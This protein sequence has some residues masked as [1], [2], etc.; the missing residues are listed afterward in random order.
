MSLF[1]DL[2]NRFSKTTD[3]DNATPLKDI[4]QVADQSPDELKLVANI[5]EKINLVR[6][7]NSR[8]ALE[9]IY[10]TNLAY[11]MGFDG[12]YYD[13]TYRMFKNIDP[14]RKVTRSRYK[15][16]KILASIQ[17]RLARLVQNPPRYDVMPESPS[18]K[19]K[20]SA[21]LGIKL[22]GD[23][24]EKNRFDE[25]RQDLLMSCMQGGVA[26]VKVKWDPT[27]G[28]PM[29]DPETDE[30]VGYEGD[31]RLEVLN[32]LEVYPDPLAKKLEDCQYVIE[33]KVRKL[34]Y[35]K[36]QYP[37]RGHAVKEE[38]VW[39]L[40][41][42][43]DL[44]ANALTAVGITGAQTKD[45]TRDSAI[46]IT[47]YE[48]R[49]KNYPNGRQVVQASGVLL[50][51]KELPAGIFDIVKFD[52]ILI[53]GRYNSEAVITHLRPIQDQF[54]ITR[55]RM[56]DWIRKNLAG[57]YI[58]PKGSELMEESINNADSEV[59]EYTTVPG[60]PPPT[61]MNIPAIPAYAYNDIKEQGL[62]FDYVSGINEVSR[63]VLPS[64]SIPAQ[65]MALLQ[66]QDQTRI[67]VQATRNEVG[68]S[69]VGELILRYAGKYYIL[70]RMYKEAGDGLEYTV[71]EF[72]GSDLNDN[73]DVRVVPGSTIP[74]SKV[75][76]RQDVM[77]VYNS[78][79]MG[80]PMDDKVKMKA[81]NE[82]EFGDTA[83]IWKSQAL[84]SNQ[85]KKSIASIEEG[86]LPEMSEFD[87]HPA[88]LL[89]MND[90][91]KSDKFQQLDLKKRGLFLYVMEWHL[92]AQIDIQNPQLMQQ[93][94]SAEAAIAMHPFTTQD[95]MKTLD[96]FHPGS[97]ENVNSMPQQSFGSGGTPPGAPMDFSGAPMA[98]PPQ[99]PPQPQQLPKF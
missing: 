48:K 99:T 81:L 8:I 75:L 70:P 40:S 55:S 62:E 98:P 56:A 83:E 69:K 13:S 4:K 90:Y 57:K 47:Y 12:V 21:R 53:G 25:L 52:D 89:E 78:G 7:T 24:L 82:L 30:L 19:D 88:H 37:D 84:D 60:A 2:A 97:P 96:Q 59:V 68:Y 44:K 16:N 92:Q 71:K 64:A 27:L 9:G 15:V 34:E 23:V 26:Y 67:G 87:N 86:Q 66:E 35:F 1:S 39:L 43:Y 29:L 95:T 33:A 72:V 14:K 3:K 6:M 41:S 80:N 22:I 5:R 54:N 10:M 31:I 51:D 45:Q 79:L 42:L 46:E 63:G 76:R 85:I 17:N 93:K 32:C 11:L 73:Y 50:E 91:R 74:T 65:G 18:T 77:N 61:A 36:E 49:S 20:D 28:A 58:V 38:D 94:L